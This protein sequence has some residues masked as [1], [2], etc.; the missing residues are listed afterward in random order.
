MLPRRGCQGSRSGSSVHGA[1]HIGCRATKLNLTLLTACAF[2]RAR[3]SDSFSEYPRPPAGPGGT[4]RPL[5]SGHAGTGGT[6][7]SGHAGR[8]SSCHCRDRSA[9][10]SGPGIMI[11]ARRRDAAG[12]RPPPGPRQLKLNS[13]WTQSTVTARSGGSDSDRDSGD[14][15][16][17]AAAAARAVARPRPAR[18]RRRRVRDSDSNHWQPLESSYTKP[19]P[20]R[21]RRPG[22]NRDGGRFRV[23]DADRESV[24]SLRL[25][26]IL[27][28]G[29]AVG[30]RI[31]SESSCD[32]STADSDHDGEQSN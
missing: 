31:S 30:R 29:P 1:V 27:Q 26:D 11:G 21:R 12:P 13:G 4:L 10:A 16:P 24:E 23:P 32:P 8:Y 7:P 22:L 18:R 6:L 15:C 19:E 28:V 2:S 17:A 5:P 25:V 14:R 9:R 3:R 20:F